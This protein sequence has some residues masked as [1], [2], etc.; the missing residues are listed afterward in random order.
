MPTETNSNTGEPAFYT[1][2]KFADKTGLSRVTVY[3]LIARGK[4]KTNPHLR[5][6]IIPPSEYER[7]NRGEF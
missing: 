1:A 3:R 7:W 5:T 6:K 2:Q 4:I